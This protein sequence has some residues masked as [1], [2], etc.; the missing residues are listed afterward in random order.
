MSLITVDYGTVG[1]GGFT[2]TPLAVNVP[3][4]GYTFT[5]DYKVVVVM[6]NG[7][8]NATSHALINGNAS[9]DTYTNPSVVDG[10]SRYLS[11]NVFYDVKSGDVLTFTDGVQIPTN[12][13]L[14]S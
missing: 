7:K 13:V 9:T 3:A 12:F 1:G 2:V 11:Y 14:I 5:D 8:S 10:G 4:A 6:T